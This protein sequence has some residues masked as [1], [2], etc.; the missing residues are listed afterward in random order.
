M[1]D[2]VTAAHFIPEASAEE[3]Q[4]AST[5]EWLESNSMRGRFG[6]PIFVRGALSAPSQASPPRIEL[7]VQI[8]ILTANLPANSPLP[9]LLL[10]LR[11]FSINDPPPCTTFSIPILEAR[12]FLF[13]NGER[14]VSVSFEASTVSTFSQR[15]GLAISNYFSRVI[16]EPFLLCGEWKYRWGFTFE[17]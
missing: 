8:S 2:L 6:S 17:D 5:A 11:L 13:A 9:S 7:S 16:F 14:V 15:R 4:E 3:R 10:V 12:G 1:G